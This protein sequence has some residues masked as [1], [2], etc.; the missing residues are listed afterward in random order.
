MHQRN[1]SQPLV[2]ALPVQLKCKSQ[3]RARWPQR[4]SDKAGGKKEHAVMQTSAHLPPRRPPKHLPIHY[5]ENSNLPPSV[6]DP[7]NTTSTSIRDGLPGSLQPNI[8]HNPSLY[9][10]VNSSI[11]P[12]HPKRSQSESCEE[13][14]EENYASTLSKYNQIHQRKRS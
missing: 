13:L 2:H 4:G 1:N 12:F 8:S 10:N 9:D 3:V 11:V 7:H 5:R 6:H 14:Q